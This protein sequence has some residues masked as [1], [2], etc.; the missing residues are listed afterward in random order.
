MRK[1][2]VV[3][4]L[5]IA[6]GIL[7]L[8]GCTSGNI[9]ASP[10]S[11]P[12]GTRDAATKSTRLC[13]VN[14]SSNPVKLTFTKFDTTE[15][16]QKRDFNLEPIFGSACAEG[17]FSKTPDVAAVIT[18]PFVTGGYSTWVATG[19]NTFLDLPTGELLNPNG[20]GMCTTLEVGQKKSVS[21]DAV[22]FTLERHQDSD[23]KEIYL[24][25]EDSE[26]PTALFK[27]NTPSVPGS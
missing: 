13:V 27:C 8:S 24:T 14:H 26:G 17:W 4:A 22:K 21:T 11:T 18:F 2:H 3:I 7:F 23:W 19:T 15:G 16:G 25:L 12:V 5:A 1:L 20:R 6:S 9:V 10:T